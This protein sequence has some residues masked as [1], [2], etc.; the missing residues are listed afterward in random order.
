MKKL[1]LVAGVA[2][3]AGSLI[4]GCA[5]VDPLKVRQTARDQRVYQEKT[6][7]PVPEARYK[8]AIVCKT[9]ASRSDKKYSNKLDDYSVDQMESAVAN[10]LSGLGW[11]DPLD[12]KHG[13]VI[14][15]EALIGNNVNFDKLPAADYV[16]VADSK[17]SFIAKQG[18]KR[19]TH[20]DKARGAMIETDFRLVDVKSKEVVFVK[21]FRSAVTDSAKGAIKE[22]V[23]IAANRNAKKLSRFVAARFLP[24][25]RVLQM[26][27]NGQ[28]AQ[29][30]MGKNYQATPAVKNWQ[31]WP[32]KYFPLCY[33]KL[34]DVPAAK[35]EFYTLEQT[36][37]G[38]KAKVV[39]NVFAKGSV[40]RAERDKA[41]VEIDDYEKA[42]VFKGHGV[43]ISEEVAEGDDLE[44]E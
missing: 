26:R 12:R 10:N 11:F 3:L 17:V 5:T 4:T 35:V 9:E 44:L 13:L 42:G 20:V 37:A 18:W 7:E 21:K 25:R 24:G 41:W 36:D 27:G 29:V 2:A 1:V 40:I 22:A 23:T 33:L 28:Y 6:K 32:Y 15:A 30:D 43:R 16:L 31:W 14:D 34:E 8:I 19:T 39:K 38:G